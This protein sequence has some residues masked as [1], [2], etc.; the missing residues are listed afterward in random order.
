[1]RKSDLQGR[2]CEG[3]RRLQ[4]KHL[5]PDSRFCRLRTYLSTLGL[6][7]KHTSHHRLLPCIALGHH[8][9][10]ALRTEMKGRSSFLQAVTG[11]EQLTR[12]MAWVHLQPRDSLGQEGGD[13]E[14]MEGQGQTKGQQ[15][16]EGE[17]KGLQSPAN[18]L[19]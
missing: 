13:A 9:R 18:H 1:M 2:G 15:R 10:Q 5:I 8:R 12:G 3:Y 16:G 19:Q 11:G 14:A 6:C 7:S 17:T 4:G